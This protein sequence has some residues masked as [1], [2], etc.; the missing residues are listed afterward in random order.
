MYLV[1]GNFV[2][3]ENFE[4]FTAFIVEIL[5]PTKMQSWKFFEESRDRTVQMAAARGRWDILLSLGDGKA[6]IVRR[7]SL[8]SSQKRRG[9]LS[10]DSY[11]KLY[12]RPTWQFLAK[13]F[14]QI[15]SFRKSFA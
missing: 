14:H 3:T 5:L 1:L 4:L 7:I 9:S 15:D 11:P 2:D 6:S 12:V 8:V 13:L 10:G